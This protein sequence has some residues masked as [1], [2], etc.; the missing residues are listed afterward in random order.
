M[1]TARN[2]HNVQDDN[3]AKDYSNGA[4]VQ[5]LL[6]ICNLRLCLCAY[7]CQSATAIS[8]TSNVQPLKVVN[9]SINLLSNKGP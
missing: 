6:F 4:S 1:N 8:T 5:S 9:Q 3:N 7:A 2:K